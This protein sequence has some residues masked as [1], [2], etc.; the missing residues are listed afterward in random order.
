MIIQWVTIHVKDMETSRKFYEDILGLKV[1]RSFSPG[2]GRQITFLGM[3]GG[4]QIELICEEG[5]GEWAVEEYAVGKRAFEEHVTEECAAGQAVSVGILAED[6]KNIYQKS[7]EKGIPR[8]E[9][10]VLGKN[11]ECFFLTDPNG[12]RLQIIRG[13]EEQ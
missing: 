3:D 13:G 7:E 1:L 5:A 6:F 2:P 9:R 10:K 12:V 4:S 8:T 11:T